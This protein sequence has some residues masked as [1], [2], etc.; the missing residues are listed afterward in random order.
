MKL[1][2]FWKTDTEYK[3]GWESH[4]T[5]IVKI[6]YVIYIFAPSTF[7]SEILFTHLLQSW[8]ENNF[9][10]KVWPDGEWGVK[11]MSLPMRV[12]G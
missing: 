8:L 4:A 12:F 6:Q 1:E 11:R 2:G 10:L 5:I 3:R 9:S 7:N